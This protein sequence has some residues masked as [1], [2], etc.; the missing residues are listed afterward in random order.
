MGHSDSIRQ[1]LRNRP[2]AAL[3]GASALS[4][5]GDWIYLTAL[6]VLVFERTH[7]P[8]LVGLA[9]AGRLV[10]FFL[11]S[12]PAG[13]LADRV[14]PRT[15][16]IATELLRCVAMLAI[17][18]LCLAGAEVWTI[19]ATTLLAAAAGTFSLPALGSLVPTLST[20]DDELGRANAIR[21]TLDSLAGVA[22]PALA[23]VLIVGGGLPL[24]FAL[25][26]V[27]FAVVAGTLLVSG[28]GPRRDQDGEPPTVE[29][30]RPSA[31]HPGKDLV[32]EIAGQ[33]ILDGAISFASAALGMLTVLIAADW[34]QAGASFTGALNMGAG[35]GGIAGGLAAGAVINGHGRRGVLVG[36]IGF[37]GALTLLGSVPIPGAAV[38][39]MVVAFGALVLLDTL[40]MTAVQRRTADGTT[41]RAIGLLHT[42]AALWMMA[43]VVLPTVVRATLGMQAAIL[44]PAVVMLGL[45]SLAVVIDGRRHRRAGRLLAAG[46]AA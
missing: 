32:R 31:D 38:G 30:V 46:V 8:A 22:A 16:L 18:W 39:A 33:L 19:I 6:P 42:L 24:A 7:E 2:L 28:P 45:G 12:M 35:L 34:L 21:S 23:G 40:N 9:A 14:P 27:S 10:P 5:A 37:A 4:G 20:D 17:A 36:V 26:G 13:V 3:V 43:G 15:I 41:G 29:P 11:L 25:N 44:V 1:L